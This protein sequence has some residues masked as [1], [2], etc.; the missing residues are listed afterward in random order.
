MLILFDHVTPKGIAGALPHHTVTK[1]KNRE[2]DRLSNG[3]LPSVAE[4]A[5]FD[6]LVTADKKHALSAEPERLQDSPCGAE[7]SAMGGCEITPRTDRC[8]RK[9]GDARQLYRFGPSMNPDRGPSEPALL[10]FT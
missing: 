10:V 3:D 2:W 4:Q 1:A 8:R 6:V 5:G 9:R 7:H